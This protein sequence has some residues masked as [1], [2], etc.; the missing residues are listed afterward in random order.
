MRT[1]INKI[2]STILLAGACSILSAQD[3]D[4]LRGKI[5]DQTTGEPV[6]FATVRIKG[7]AKG[8]VTNMDG[9]FRLPLSYREAGESIE[10][11][12]MGYEKKE[13]EL[14]KLSPKD[15]NVIRLNLGVVSLREAIVSAKKKRKLSAKR[16]VRTAIENIPKN[17]PTYPF[18]TI[19]YYRDYQIE[20]EEYI[21]LNEAILEVFDAGFSKI[22]T[23]TTKVRI[24]DYEQNHQFK[25]DTLA[26]DPYDYT[27]GK[28]TIVNAFLSDYG[29]NEFSILKTHD[30]IRNYKL[31]TYDFINRM[32]DG[33][34]LNNH[35]FKKLAD[36]YISHKVL[37]V[38][39]FEKRT[40]SYVAVG[41]MYISTKDFAIHNLEYAVYD[42]LKRNKN[43]KLRERGIKGELIFEVRAEYQRN[44]ND[45][46]YLNYISFHNTF[47]LRL[48]PRFTLDH[49]Q[50][51]FGKKRFELAFNKE[52]D[53]VNDLDYDNYE[54]FFK[55]KSIKFK[56][57]L[58][59]ENRVFLYP[60]LNSKKGQI[61][62]EELNLA[63]KGK[64]LTRELI[65]FKVKDIRDI[66]GNL[67]N[68]PHLK[69]Y[70]QFREFF[71]QEV[72]PFARGPKDSLY[73]KKRRPIFENQPIIK[74][75][76]FDDYWMNTPLQK[77]EN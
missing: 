40:S 31:N 48:L 29:G 33:D 18:S 55:K 11:S 65:N 22:D 24:Y 19:G 51:D 60:D 76:N 27:R 75:A 35:S 42:N 68:Q 44:S 71:V 63:A 6:V 47:Q 5:L 70:N 13:Y 66:D 4:Y 1:F 54:G 30:A 61:M 3:L 52:I 77:F 53:S 12:S 9:G 17:Y 34:I 10:I 32:E 16:I 74:P 59:F 41:K 45:K 64:I 20:K 50:V 25:R 8:V 37:Y 43:D 56:K 7:M 14:L 15:I 23:S 39:A 67:I 49:I 46:M 28:K 21:N 26:D 58:V 69:D 62:W 72:K 2:V 57:L 73:M 36:S 38:V